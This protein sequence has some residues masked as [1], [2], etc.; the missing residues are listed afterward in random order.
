M[1]P[2]NV[3]C[4]QLMRDPFAIAKFLFIMDARSE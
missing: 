3:L 2:L 4:A 1:D